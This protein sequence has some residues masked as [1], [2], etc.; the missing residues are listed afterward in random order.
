MIDQT[1]R[2]KADAAMRA[3]IARAISAGKTITEAARIGGEAYKAALLADALHAAGTVAPLPSSGMVGPRCV[4][5]ED[6]K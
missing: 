4:D 6:E 3:A 1:P 2:E 5:A